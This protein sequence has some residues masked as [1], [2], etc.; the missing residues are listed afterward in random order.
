LKYL[1]IV[2]KDRAKF[3]L[4]RGDIL[5]NRTNS[6]ELVGKSAVFDLERDFACQLAEIALIENS[7]SDN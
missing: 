6:A 2:D 3:V 5:V 1:H 4:K 7:I